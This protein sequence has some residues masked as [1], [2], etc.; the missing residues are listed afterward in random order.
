MGYAVTSILVITNID[1][2]I[3]GQYVQHYLIT[4]HSLT[5]LIINNAIV[6]IIMLLILELT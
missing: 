2:S 6:V 4:L 3:M 1:Y 5:F